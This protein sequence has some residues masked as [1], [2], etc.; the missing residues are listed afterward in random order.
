[1]PVQIGTPKLGCP[2]MFQRI[3]WH[4]SIDCISWLAGVGRAIIHRLARLSTIGIVQRTPFRGCCRVRRKESVI[5]IRSATL[6]TGSQSQC[7]VL[8]ES[9]LESMQFASGTRP[10]KNSREIAPFRRG[11]GNPLEYVAQKFY[12]VS[13]WLLH[14]YYLIRGT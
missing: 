8:R 4:R 5:H 14:S 13:I 2:C 10:Q 7:R 3:V 12:P 9:T 1:M 11:A 6:K